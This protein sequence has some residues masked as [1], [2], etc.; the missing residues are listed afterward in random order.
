MKTGS[1]R[2]TAY[3]R[4]TN[5]PMILTIQKGV[6]TTLFPALSLAIHCS[7]NLDA[8]ANCPQNPRIIQK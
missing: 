6:G 1:R 8:K 2:C 4:R 5:D 7:R 3:A